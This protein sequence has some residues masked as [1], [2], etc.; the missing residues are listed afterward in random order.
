MEEI[1]KTKEM[2]KEAM[3]TL[4]NQNIKSIL[5]LKKDRNVNM[6]RNCSDIDA[7]LMLQ[8]EIRILE[9][10]IDENDKE[11]EPFTNNVKSNFI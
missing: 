10:R 8:K 6:I 5:F 1:E 7:Y 4:L 9:K 11:T 2:L 3:Q